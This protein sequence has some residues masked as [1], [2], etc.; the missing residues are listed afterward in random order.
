[1]MLIE[2]PQSD[3][4]Y[5]IMNMQHMGPVLGL[6]CPIFRIRG[7]SYFISKEL[8]NQ[9]SSMNIGKLSVQSKCSPLTPTP[10]PLLVCYDFICLHHFHKLILG[11]NIPRLANFL[12]Y[13]PSK[14]LLLMFSQINNFQF[15]TFNARNFS[16]IINSQQLMLATFFTNFTRNIRNILCARQFVRSRY[17]SGFCGTFLCHDI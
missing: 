14:D 4:R 16:Q 2:Q 3:Y 15:A 12:Y 10:K 5:L 11:Y 7:G 9:K 8:H 17:T 13:R 1:M 6:Y